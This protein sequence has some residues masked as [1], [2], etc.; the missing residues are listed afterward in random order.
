[1]ILRYLIEKEFKQ[2]R[3]DIFLPRMMLMYPLMILLVFPW[4]VNMEIKNLNLAVLDNSGGPYAVRM[5]NKAS[6]SGYFRTVSFPSDFEAAMA[7]IE[8]G[9]A[10]LILEIPSGFDRDIV[11]EKRVPVLISTNAVDGMKGGL[12][13]NYLASIVSDFNREISEE[14][15]S[16][17]V[18][19]RIDTLKINRFNPHQD[20]KVY[21]IPAF[22]VIILTLICGFLPA[23][24]IVGEKE[25]GTI[26]QINVTPVPKMIFILSKLIP[27][28]ILGFLLL[29]FAILIAGFVYDLWPVGG[30]GPLYLFCLIFIWVISAFGLIISNY[31]QTMQQAM[32]VMFFFLIVY[33]LLS[34]LFTPIASMPLWARAIT[35]F[36]PLRYLIEAMRSIYLRGSGISDLWLQMLCLCGFAVV[37]SCWAVWSYRKR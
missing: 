17:V 32:F 23:L 6:A 16:P 13:S 12:G 36:N 1:M 5:V 9:K 30:A 18:V 28:W 27:Y 29:S 31:S 35:Y 20:Y 14:I 21:M 24:N 7:D 33:I 19:P 8:Q 26:E 11:R 4:A 2:F 34:G 3:R 22:M 15:G 37:F 10:D 25:K